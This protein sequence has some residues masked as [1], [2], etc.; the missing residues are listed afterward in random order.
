MAL[1]TRIPAIAAGLRPAVRDGVRQ[2][3]EIVV[4]RAA[5]RVHVDNGDLR[6]AIHLERGGGGYYV[7]AGGRTPSGVDVFWGNFV[8]NGTSHSPPY[9]FLVP[10]LEE[11]RDDV[12]A[13]VNAAVARARFAGRL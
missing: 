11:S 10:A 13:A 8:E 5:L 2:G 7:V 9:P 12:I 6:D 1:K 4:H 3:A